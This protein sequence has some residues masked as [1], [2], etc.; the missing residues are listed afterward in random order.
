MGDIGLNRGVRHSNQLALLDA[1]DGVP[2]YRPN[3]LPLGDQN[4][5]IR[6]QK[7][8]ATGDAVDFAEEGE[9]SGGAIAL[10]DPLEEVLYLLLGVDDGVLADVEVGGLGAVDLEDAVV[11]LVAVAADEIESCSGLV[12]AE[13]LEGAGV[14]VDVGR[15]RGFGFRHGK[16]RTERNGTDE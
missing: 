14:G 13:F 4:Q 6:L 8:N 15:R 9:A 5:I 11:L 16:N 2:A 10:A 7:L 1:V 12:E 3:L